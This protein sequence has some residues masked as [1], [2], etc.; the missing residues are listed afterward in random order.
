M[1]ESPAAGTRFG[2]IRFTAAP[3]FAGR[4]EVELQAEDGAARLRATSAGA[5]QSGWQ[6][7]V[8][9]H[10]V[11]RVQDLIDDLPDPAPLPE[12]DET[13]GTQYRLSVDRGDHVEVFEWWD[14]VPAGWEAVARL[15][16]VLL[17]LAG[18]R[19]QAAGIW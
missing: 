7:A 14:N 15:V 10:D 18:P 3:T 1:P 16:D 6:L 12:R 11:K 2:P 4:L 17:V 19:A 8:A 9:P 5:E 13:D